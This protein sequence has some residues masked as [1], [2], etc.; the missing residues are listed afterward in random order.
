MLNRI[1]GTT[2]LAPW[3]LGLCIL[4]L[5]A[6][7]DRLHKKDFTRLIDGLAQAEFG[8]VTIYHDR[9]IRPQFPILVQALFDG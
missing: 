4:G 6:A 2:G 7:P 9:D 8:R 5:L 1:G 3:H